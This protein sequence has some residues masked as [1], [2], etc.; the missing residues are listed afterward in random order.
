MVDTCTITRPGA[1]AGVFDPVTGQTAPAAASALYAGRCWTKTRDVGAQAQQVAG[2]AVT[3]MAYVVS[4]PWDTTG[5]E[6]G[7]RVTITGSTDPG[8]V[9]RVLVVRS[10]EAS[11][12]M[13][14]RRLTC[15]DDQG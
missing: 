7:D 5:I 9:D 10:V 8:A 4:I 13:T 2:Q 3:E 12:F 11:T 1:G 6:V 15:T 14:A